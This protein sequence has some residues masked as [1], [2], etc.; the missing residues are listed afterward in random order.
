MIFKFISIKFLGISNGYKEFK[1]DDLIDFAFHE[2][3]GCSNLYLLKEIKAQIEFSDDCP[4]LKDY[5]KGMKLP[6]IEINFVGFPIVQK[7]S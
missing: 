3:R 5:K 6:N 1:K 2:K 7:E 4:P